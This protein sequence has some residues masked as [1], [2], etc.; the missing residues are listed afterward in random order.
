M[1]IIALKIMAYNILIKILSIEENHKHPYD[2]YV[3]AHAL[4]LG[5]TY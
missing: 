5:H 2:H 3:H 4:D 1:H